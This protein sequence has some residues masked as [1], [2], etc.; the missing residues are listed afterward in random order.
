MNQRTILWAAPLALDLA[1]QSARL[2]G[3]PIELGPKVFAL[4]HTLMEAPQRVVTKEALFDSVWDGRFV[5]EA[6]LTTAMKELRRA[7]GDD[8]RE[9]QFIATV[10]G[11]GYRFLKPVETKAP[12]TGAAP[13]RRP[14]PGLLQHPDAGCS[15]F[16]R[17]LR[18][19]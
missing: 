2:D 13:Q 12:E 4:L 3:R 17:R 10:H 19:C 6:V 5:S 1:D 14:Q 7:L 16:Q 9:P 8:A 11:K 15:A 18:P